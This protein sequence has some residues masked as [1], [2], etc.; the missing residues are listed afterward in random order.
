MRTFSLDKE[1]TIVLILYSYFRRYGIWFLL[2]FLL[3]LVL[4]IFHV[5][6]WS[7]LII[8]VLF[9]LPG[10]GHAYNFNNKI[11]YLLLRDYASKDK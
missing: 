3:Y 1:P 4:G 11:V 2:M 8:I 10:Y 5:T 6:N 7:F 9:L